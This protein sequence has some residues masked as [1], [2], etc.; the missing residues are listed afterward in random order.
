ERLLEDLEDVD[1]PES[2]KDMQR[3]C[4]G[5]STGAHITFNV[6]GS[7]ED[8]TVFTTRPETLFGVTYAVLAAEH[9]LVNLITTAEQREAVS[10]Y[11]HQARL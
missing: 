5:K 7:N 3:N 8:F 11:K 9:D 2:I 1:W 6:S 4:I 10:E